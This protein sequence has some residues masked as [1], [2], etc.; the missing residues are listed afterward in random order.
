ML[1]TFVVILTIM[2]LQTSARHQIASEMRLS[3]VF[4]GVSGGS[5]DIDPEPFKASRMAS[6]SAKRHILLLIFN[7]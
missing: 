6:S 3:G 4:N 2:E 5:T 1:F 7:R